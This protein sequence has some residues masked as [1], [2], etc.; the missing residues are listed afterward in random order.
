MIIGIDPG[1]SGAIALYDP[2]T[3]WLEIHDMPVVK[4]PK[5]KMELMHSAVLDILKED[6]ATV[7]MEQ[8]AARAGQGV[9]SMFRFG[10]GY[11]AL[12]MAVTANQHVLRYV[13]PSKWKAYFGIGSDKDVSRGLAQTR[14]PKCADKFARKKDDGRAEASL[15]ALYGSE[16]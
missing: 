8:V 10:Q 7:W 12:Q 4:T 6:N 16:Q 5:G 2:A 9:S 11:G 3:N 14:F 13:P 1:F 15:I